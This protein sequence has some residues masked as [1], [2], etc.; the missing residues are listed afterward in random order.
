[1][2]IYREF[3]H[4]TEYRGNLLELLLFFLMFF[5]T[6]QK[7][8][9]GTLSWHSSWPQARMPELRELLNEILPLETWKEIDKRF[10][11]FRRRAKFVP[12]KNVMYH[13]YMGQ[14][15]WNWT[16]FFF[17]LNFIFRDLSRNQG[18]KS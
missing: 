17:F 6:Y 13:L 4:G 12:K 18:K 7:E 16:V 14:E 5:L 8:H 15:V 10:V 1:M 9:N 2:P 3:H 11:A